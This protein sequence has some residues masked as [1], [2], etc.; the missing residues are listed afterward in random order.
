MDLIGPPGK[1][2]LPQRDEATRHPSSNSAPNDPLA[3]GKK[4]AE[5]LESYN[6]LHFSGSCEIRPSFETPPLL[7]F[8]HIERHTPALPAPDTAG[9]PTGCMGRE[10]IFSISSVR[11]RAGTENSRVF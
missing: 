5:I 3:R 2:E 1:S 6:Q 9:R 7:S 10:P 8:R 11:R 4:E